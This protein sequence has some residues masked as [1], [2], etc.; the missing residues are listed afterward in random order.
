[1]SL[2]PKKDEKIEL[3]IRRKQEGEMLALYNTS[4]FLMGF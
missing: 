2:N 1:M 4:V 3:M